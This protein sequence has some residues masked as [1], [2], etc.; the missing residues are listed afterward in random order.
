MSDYMRETNWRQ[1]WDIPALVEHMPTTPEPLIV[2]LGTGDGRILKNLAER[3]VPGRFVGIDSSEAAENHFSRRKQEFGFPGEFVYADFMNPEFAFSEPVDAA[4]FGSVSV[5]CLNTI[6][7]LVQLFHSAD[8]LLAPR[9]SLIL[10]V[11]TDEA[12]KQL[13]NLDG[14]LDV[15][16]YVSET[17]AE[18]LMWRGLRLRGTD[19]LHNAFVDRHAEGLPSVICWE[20]ERAWSESDVTEI[21]SAVGWKT[22]IRNISSVAEGGADGYEVA[23]LSF[24]RDH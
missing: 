13:I 17:G 24:V 11:Y 15:D 10:S 3:G 5:N 21:A 12:A 6:D 8:R 16:P 22:S 19:F 18:R 23:T 7:S 9:G 14:V 4:I 1:T 20:R 2:D